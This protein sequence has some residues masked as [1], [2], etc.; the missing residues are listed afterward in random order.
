ML[1]GI[2]ALPWTL[3]FTFCALPCS[4]GAGATG[5]FPANRVICRCC[6]IGLLFFFLRI[7]Q[8]QLGSKMQDDAGCLSLH[9]TAF[10]LRK[11]FPVGDFCCCYRDISYIAIRK[12]EAK[13]TTI[14]ESIFKVSNRLCTFGTCFYLLLL[15]GMRVVASNRETRA[16]RDYNLVHDNGETSVPRKSQLGM[17]PRC[18]AFLFPS[19]QQ[20]LM[21]IRVRIRT[22]ERE[23][24]VVISPTKMDQ[25]LLVSCFPSESF[26]SKLSKFPRGSCAV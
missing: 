25:G 3:G 18:L 2:W 10:I 13:G 21:L 14:G 17:I 4:S 11:Q 22:F 24:Q 5:V 7:L 8:L 20:P 19:R 1:I 23:V 12:D 15:L 6:N 16:R 9:R 26:N